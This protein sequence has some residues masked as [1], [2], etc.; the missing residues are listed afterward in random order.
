MHT[1]QSYTT[2]I[3]LFRTPTINMTAALNMEKDT[4][5]ICI[6][7]S[8]NIRACKGTHL[9]ELLIALYPVVQTC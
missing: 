6:K 5:N 1:R 7:T 8:G 4:A 3:A 2:T 9:N